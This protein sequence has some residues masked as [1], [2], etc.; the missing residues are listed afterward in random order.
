MEELRLGMT[1]TQVLDIL[2]MTN[3]VAATDLPGLSIGFA[4]ATLSY[5]DANGKWTLVLDVVKDGVT[6][7][8]YR[9]SISSNW[10]EWVGAIRSDG[11]KGRTSDE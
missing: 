8:A 1:V 10:I 5:F 4:G 2:G 7:V 6:R 9:S 11:M 3:V